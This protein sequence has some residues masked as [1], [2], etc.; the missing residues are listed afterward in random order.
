M[1]V[2]GNIAGET[3]TPVVPLLGDQALGECETPGRPDD[4]DHDGSAGA[5]TA[6]PATPVAPAAASAPISFTG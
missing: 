4:H 6:T 2:V 3:A 5:G 1:F